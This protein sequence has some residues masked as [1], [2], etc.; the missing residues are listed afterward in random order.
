MDFFDGE[1][2]SMHITVNFSF[3]TVI[4]NMAFFSP[5]FTNASPTCPP[6]PTTVLQHT[7]CIT[8]VYMLVSFFSCQCPHI[9]CCNDIVHSSDLVFACSHIF[10]T[11]VMMNSS[12][13][14]PFYFKQWPIQYESQWGIQSRITCLGQSRFGKVHLSS[15][16]LWTWSCTHDNLLRDDEL[17]GDVCVCYK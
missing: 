6:P 5:M 10:D 8:S 7:R 4:E 11:L 3:A 15:Y 2:H 14:C 12:R 13:C 17:K 9:P 16:G 1:F